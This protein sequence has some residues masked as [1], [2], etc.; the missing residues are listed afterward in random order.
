MT[1]SP[2]HSINVDGLHQAL[3]ELGLVQSRCILYFVVPP[4][5]YPIFKNPSIV[6]SGKSLPDNVA[7]MVL[8]LPLQRRAE[9]TAAPDNAVGPAAGVK[10]KVSPHGQMLVCEEL[11]F[12]LPHCLLICC[13]FLVLVSLRSAYLQT[14]SNHQPR[15]LLRLTVTAV[16]AAR[17]RNVRAESKVTSAAFTATPRPRHQAL[18]PMSRRA[19][20]EASML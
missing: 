19:S 20:G 12:S 14:S 7:L 9:P 15:N 6:P 8:E 5:I 1:V 10:R 16:R 13:V 2:T 4:D 18:A 17:T 3:T 11:C